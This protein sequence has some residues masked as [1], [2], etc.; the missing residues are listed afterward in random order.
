MNVN[1]AEAAPNL[2]RALNVLGKEQIQQ[3]TNKT[4][5]KLTV[6]QPT[7]SDAVM[8]FKYFA[9]TRTCS[10]WMNYGAGIPVRTQYE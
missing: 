6:R 9:P 7:E 1:K 10:P 8:V 2:E 3:M 4:I 5:E